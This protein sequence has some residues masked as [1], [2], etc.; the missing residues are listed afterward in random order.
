MNIPHEK[1][2][3]A[4][5]DIASHLFDASIQSKMKG[6]FVAD[7]FPED[8]R[9]II[10]SYLQGDILSVT[11]IFMRMRQVESDMEHLPKTYFIKGSV[12]NEEH[13]Y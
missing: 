13:S 2:I 11:A 6:G 1:V 10:Q 3:K 8:E 9:E 12:S 7:D 4:G 5:E